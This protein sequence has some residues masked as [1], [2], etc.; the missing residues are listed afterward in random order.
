[1]RLRLGLL[2]LV[3]TALTAL[4]AGAPPAAA[5]S[6][7]WP[8]AAPHHVVRGFAPPAHDWLPGHR[9]VDLAASPREAVLAAGAGR[10]VLAADV[11]GVG[12]VA[13]AHPDGFETTYEPVT[14]AIRVGAEVSAGSVIG[15]LRTDHGH[16]GSRPC[17]HWGLRRDSHYLDPLTLVGAARVRLLPLGAAGTAWVVPAVS[18]ASVGSSAV[19]LGWAFALRRRRRRPLPAG[20]VDLD[21]ARLRVSSRR[22]RLGSSRQR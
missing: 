7:V 11:G 4:V 19:V 21:H 16:C 9:G 12:V 8:L 22:P 14:P 17:L 5:A 3:A 20:V 1:M 2:A 10:V 6:W 13:I 15:R 18:G